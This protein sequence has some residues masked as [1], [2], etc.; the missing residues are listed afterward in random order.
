MC[1]SFLFSRY[2]PSNHFSD[3]NNSRIFPAFIGYRISETGYCALVS[4][5]D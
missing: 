1:S 4:I 2:D 3:Q 5:K